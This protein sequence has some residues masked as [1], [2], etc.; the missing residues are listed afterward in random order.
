MSND[1]KRANATR[2]LR[3]GHSSCRLADDQFRSDRVT[4][5]WPDPRLP[6]DDHGADGFDRCE[7]QVLRQ[8]G[9][10]A[11]PDQGRNEGQETVDQGHDAAG[12]DVRQPVR[13]KWKQ[14]RGENHRDG[15]FHQYRRTR[16]DQLPE[17]R[18][19]RRWRAKNGPQGNN[20]RIQVV[21][22]RE[23]PQYRQTLLHVVHINLPRWADAPLRY[24]AT[25]RSRNA[26]T[27][28][29]TD[30][31]PVT[32]RTYR[33]QMNNRTPLFSRNSGRNP[34]R[35]CRGSVPA[36][37]TPPSSMITLPDGRS[38]SRT[39]PQTTTSRIATPTR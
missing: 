4:R 6:D 35:M 7:E 21:E 18:S 20:I 1:V 19:V 37:I 38:R 23:D 2:Q 17:V 29:I 39:A 30:S 31:P 33:V 27:A 34:F 14:S 26:W 13:P 28:R 16:E 36:A 22:Q 8:S 32:P 11:P 9:R 15:Y 24:E 25:R 10:P 5:F 12:D 3:R